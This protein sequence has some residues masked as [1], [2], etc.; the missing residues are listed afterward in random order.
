MAKAKNFA[1]S[2]VVN[3]AIW[4]REILSDLSKVQ[5]NPATIMVDN[6]STI[7]VA[8]NSAN[9][10]RTKHIKVKFMSLNKLE[11]KEK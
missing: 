2:A 4:P 11:K 6:Q 9:N 3:Q 7:T 1:A 8:K 10:G 5:V